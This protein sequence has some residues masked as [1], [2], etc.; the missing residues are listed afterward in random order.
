MTFYHLGITLIGV[1]VIAH[2]WSLLRVGRLRRRGLYPKRGG[3]T[4]ADVERL[5]EAGYSGYAMRCYREIHGGSLAST[6]EAVRTQ[7][8]QYFA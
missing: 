8:P 7:Y 6:K 2:L 5:L 4:M 1:F 3:A